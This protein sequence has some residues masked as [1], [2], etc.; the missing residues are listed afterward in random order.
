MFTL[1]ALLIALQ[2]EMRM[3][4]AP[5]EGPVALIICP[6]RELAAQS[7]E[8]ITDYCADLQKGGFPELRGMLCIGGLDGRAMADQVRDKGVH[9]VVA[10]PGRLKDLLHRKRMTLDCCRYLCL[11]EA[12][13]MVDLGFEEEVR[14]VVF[15]SVFVAARALLGPCLRQAPNGKK[16]TPTNPSTPPAPPQ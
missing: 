15:F 10:T 3:P 1:P 13:R 8:I 11:D 16:K 6:S 2:E 14:I 9:L 5:G 12:D 7:L 4:L